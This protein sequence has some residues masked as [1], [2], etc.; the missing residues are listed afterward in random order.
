MK[1]TNFTVRDLFTDHANRIYRVDVNTTRLIEELLDTK[2]KVSSD[3]FSIS[4]T[5]WLKT[6]VKVPDEYEKSFI[7][8]KK[9]YSFDIHE[10]AMRC[11]EG[12]LRI[13]EE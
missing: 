8:Y 6:N 5:N 7:S 2:P 10:D 13:A 1:L 4:P 12:M 11:S 3:K 9:Y